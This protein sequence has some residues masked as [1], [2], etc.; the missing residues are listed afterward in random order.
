MHCAICGQHIQPDEA[1]I[2]TTTGAVVHVAC[3]DREAAVAWARR[4]RWAC[5]H[6]FGV[7]VAIGMLPW[8]GAA[9]WLLVLIGVG[10]ITY[11]LINRRVWH[12]VARDIH[13]WLNRHGHK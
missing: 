5:V 4:R 11:P 7:I 13:Q 10:V 12:Y 6:L 2:A 8:I 1:H 3:A 9:P